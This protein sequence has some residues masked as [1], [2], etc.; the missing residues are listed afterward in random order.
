MLS[1]DLS[2]GTCFVQLGGPGSIGLGRWGPRLVDEHR[3][4]WSRL[5][6]GA[7]GQSKSSAAP[8]GHRPLLATG[9]PCGDR[10]TAGNPI[11]S[12]HDVGAGGF[13][14]PLPELAHSGGVGA[15]FDLRQVPIE[16]PG[17]SPAEI[18]SNESP[19]RYVLAIPPNRLAEF[20]PL[21]RVAPSP[22]RRGPGDIPDG[23]RRPFRHQSGRY[24]NGG[25]ARQA[26]AHDPRCHQPA[27]AA[28]VPFD[29]TALELGRRLSPDASAHHGRQDLPDFDRRPLGGRHDRRD[30]MVGPWQVPVADVAV[31]AMVTRVLGEAFAMGRAHSARGPRRPASVAWP[32]GE[33]ITNLPPTCGRPGPVKLS[34]NWMAPGVSRRRCPPVRHRRCVRSV[35]KALGVIPVGPFA[36]MRTARGDQARKAGV[37]L[38]LIVTAFAAGRRRAAAPLTPQLPHRLRPGGNRIAP[39]WVEPPRRLGLA[40]GL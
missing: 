32:S 16:E 8:G 23:H 1:G 40:C 3:G 20:H 28:Y 27:A 7:A 31:T 15:F 18:W 24:G 4:I 5:C 30:Q 34:A 36:S 25:P 2:A 13:P 11:L 22:C 12:V 37:A 17:M 14:M 33:A 9:K 21:R 39:D 6:I 29:A 19:E 35:G 38:S 10:A 26:A